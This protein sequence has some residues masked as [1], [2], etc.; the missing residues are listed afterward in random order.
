[1]VVVRA[2]GALVAAELL[3]ERGDPE[4]A[5]RLFSHQ[6]RDLGRR[7]IA[8]EV[9]RRAW[10][11]A[12]G[13]FGSLLDGGKGDPGVV[14]EV[15]KGVLPCERRDLPAVWRRYEDFRGLVGAM[16]S[17]RMPQVSVLTWAL[18]VW[19]EGDPRPFYAHGRALELRLASTREA[20]ERLRHV[21]DALSAYQS[22]L[23]A[24]AS[25]GAEARWRPVLSARIVRLLMEH[26]A[27]DAEALPEALSL[28]DAMERETLRRLAPPY[29]FAMA[30]AQLRSSRSM[31]RLRALDALEQLM[32]DARFRDAGQAVVEG[33][34]ESLDWSFY[35]TEQ[36]RARAIVSAF[37]GGAAKR[38][39]AYLDLLQALHGAMGRHSQPDKGHLE[40]LLEASLIADGESVSAT[41][42]R[43]AIRLAEAGEGEGEEALRGALSASGITGEGP[44][45]ALSDEP[46]AMALESLRQRV[47][48]ERQ[49]VRALLAAFVRREHR[50]PHVQAAFALL[51][52]LLVRQWGSWVELQV[53][54]RRAVGVYLQH[55]PAPSVGFAALGVALFAVGE[56]RLAEKAARRALAEVEVEDRAV[57]EPLLG[58]LAKEAL[59]AAE[60]ARAVEWLL[61]LW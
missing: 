6:A 16:L 51:V 34:L 5:L 8:A 56:P 20:G 10:F 53:E 1:M 29:R 36:D 49:V 25:V 54:M 59:D 58:R 24:A 42:Y 32:A 19:F 37:G 13:A 60:P 17:A 14:E 28:L 38:I 41:F 7:S 44:E 27:D 12:L 33:Y 15:V 52:P 46:L 18:C 40:R 57:L 9:R 55:A 30:V 23:G 3:L 50:V 26:R 4:G 48:P 39:G 45:L 22:A 31:D 2:E 47:H 35:S 61:P 11:G 21:R 43:V